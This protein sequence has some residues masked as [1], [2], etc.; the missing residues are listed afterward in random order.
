[1]NVTKLYAFRI[2]LATTLICAQT[3]AFGESTGASGDESLGESDGRVQ[4]RLI[5]N[6]QQPAVEDTDAFI[7]ALPQLGENASEDEAAPSNVKFAIASVSKV[8]N[9]QADKRT[10]AKLQHRLAGLYLL[11]ALE[12]RRTELA[13][14]KSELAKHYAEAK[15]T[16]EPQA[17]HGR[18]Q[19][20]LIKALD[21]YRN[22]LAAAPAYHARGDV[23]LNVGRILARLGSPNALPDL[24]KVTVDFPKTGY[25]DRAKLLIAELQL[26]NPKSA[27]EGENLLVSLAKSKD[28]SIRAY[29]KYRTAWTDIK[30]T[31][32]ASSDDQ[33]FGG[34]DSTSSAITTMRELAARECR[35]TPSAAGQILCR[36]IN[37]DLVFL[38]GNSQQIPVAESYFKARRDFD[39][40]YLTLERAAALYAKGR[41]FHEAGLVLKKLIHDAPT[42]EHTP[43]SYLALADAE[44]RAENP[45][46]VAEAFEQMLRDCVRAGGVFVK[47][48]AAEKT[49]VA[50]ARDLFGK[51]SAETA[52]SFIRENKEKGLSDYL[53]ASNRIFAVHLSA[54][55][56]GPESDKLRFL[57]ADGLH[58]EEKPAES[59]YQFMMVARD[60]DPSSKLKNRAAEH[61]LTLQ[62]E[63]SGPAPAITPE[64]WATLK[65]S[66]PLAKLESQLVAVSDTYGK[67]F[68]SKKVS[69]EL[70]LRAA[71]LYLAHGY[72]GDAL[73]RVKSLALAAP[74]SAPSAVGIVMLLSYHNTKREW[75]DAIK[76]ATH[77]SEQESLKNTAVQRKVGEAWRFA[78]WSKATD[79]NERKEYAA[80][81]RT[82]SSYAETFPADKAA[83]QSLVNASAAW[84]KLGNGEEG[85]KPCHTLI[86]NYGKSPLRPICLLSIASVSEQRLEYAAAAEAYAQLAAAL[87]Q[88]ADRATEAF[89]RSAELYADDHQFEASAQTLRT[90]L[91]RYPSH[92]RAPAALF[93]L[94]QVEASRGEIEKAVAAYDRYQRTYQGSHVSEALLAAANA[95][96]LQI[97]KNP[98]DAKRRVDRAA[99][100][101][102][103]AA[104]NVALE[105]RSILAAYQFERVRAGREQVTLSPI[106]ESNLTMFSKSLTTIKA[107]MRAAENAFQ[108]VIQTGDS[109][110]TV[111]ARYQLGLLYEQAVNA[112]KAAPSSGAMSG[113]ELTS[114]INQREAAILE[115]KTAMNSHWEQG[116]KTVQTGDRHNRWLRLTRAKLAQLSP[117]RFADHGEIMLKPV[118]TSHVI[119]ADMTETN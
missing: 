98:A 59:A 80:A 41:K 89:M 91:G 28:R 20:Y 71:A 16:K 42:R 70:A 21:T 101:A 36:Q 7:A 110:F 117:N 4:P 93:R 44:R 85:L 79:L 2:V 109:V 49:L 103:A 97:E 81:G 65:A 63:V 108:S 52:V 90:L 69:A 92:Q 39:R 72:A 88:Q 24:T 3:K 82:F 30:I 102:A 50:D 22:L 107:E 38:F 76:I 95:A 111:A 8:L 18:S 27:E 114:A 113:S 31:P 68:P 60:A 104:P 26:K 61:M 15:E 56:S 34:G 14:Y 73:G 87:P 58:T 1:M 66:E 115:F 55:P 11:A 33:A 29:A 40:Y 10:R 96:I 84:L 19:T 99:K 9:A 74:Q 75:D 6:W 100:L 86:A 12:T 23:A 37:D 67:I 105:A 48:H 106:D 78:L 46:A 43:W 25:A 83:D 45:G 54:F 62:L 64:A 5:S 116:A 17:D 32:A 13:E 118:F 35:T 57:Y 47:A 119:T 53:A 112:V 51:A 77:F 94:G